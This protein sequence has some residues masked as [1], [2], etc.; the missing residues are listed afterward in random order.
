MA[1]FLVSSLQHHQNRLNGE[2]MLQAALGDAFTPH[3]LKGLKA[4]GSTLVARHFSHLV[5]CGW[6]QMGTLFGPWFMW[7]RL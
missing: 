7:A 4:P 5:F 1:V 3:S 2:A 6:S